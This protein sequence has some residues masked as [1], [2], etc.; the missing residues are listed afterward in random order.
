MSDI[1]EARRAA[2]EARTEFD[3]ASDAANFARTSQV[4]YEFAERQ[5]KLSHTYEDREPLP[6]IEGNAR[7]DIAQP[8]PPTDEQVRRLEK[9]AVVA[10]KK[11]NLTQ[12]ALTDAA[13]TGPPKRKPST[14]GWSATKSFRFLGVAYDPGDPFD[15][16]VAEPGKLAQMIG[17]RLIAATSPAGAD[18]GS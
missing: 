5:W 4:N 7:Y 6:I 10:A 11:L 9:A 8:P 13:A 1:G 14:T 16:S 15:P 3:R 2:A 17:A 12:Q 18:H